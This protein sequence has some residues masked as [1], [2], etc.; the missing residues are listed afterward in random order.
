M[1]DGSLLDDMG[2]ISFSN[3]SKS[4]NENAGLSW[5]MLS[6]DRIELI[7][8]RKMGPLEMARL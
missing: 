6:A 5:V 7:C 3:D 4:F 1:S 2:N 8:G